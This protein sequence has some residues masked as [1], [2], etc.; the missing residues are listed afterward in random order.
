MSGLKG[1]DDYDQDGDPKGAPRETE[2]LHRLPVI[3]ERDANMSVL[4]YKVARVAVAVQECFDEVSRHARRWVE[5][6]AGVI[7]VE[8]A[9]VEFR[10]SLEMVDRKCG[11]GMDRAARELDE[12]IKAQVSFGPNI[13]F[14]ILFRIITAWRVWGLYTSLRLRWISQSLSPKLLSRDGQQLDVWRQNLCSRLCKSWSEVGININRPINS[15]LGEVVKAMHQGTIELGKG[16]TA[17]ACRIW[18]SA[19]KTMEDL[20]EGRETETHSYAG[21]FKVPHTW[22]GVGYLSYQKELISQKIVV[23]E[24]FDLIHSILNAR[25][26]FQ[27]TPKGKISPGDEGILMPFQRAIE[28]AIGTLTASCAALEAYGPFARFDALLSAAALGF[29]KDVRD[30]HLSP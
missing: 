23:L 10:K 11:A 13:R 30:V 24:S 15:Y 7:E 18:R 12:G 2:T 6:V 8:A 14:L 5:G 21:E 4:Q 27:G 20:E 25:K 3:L 29:L 9:C 1:Y 16:C 17:S 19:V 26:R 28:G 22:R